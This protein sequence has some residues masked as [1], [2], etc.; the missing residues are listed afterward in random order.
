MK[1]GGE[2]GDQ[3]ETEKGNRQESREREKKKRNL[4]LFLRFE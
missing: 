1:K 3:K 2:K 4:L